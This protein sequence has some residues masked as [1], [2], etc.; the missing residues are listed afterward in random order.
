MDEKDIKLH[1][2]TGIYYFSRVSRNNVRRY[3]SSQ[4]LTVIVPGHLIILVPLLNTTFARATYVGPHVTLRA[5]S[6]SSSFRRLSF[7]TQENAFPKAFLS[8]SS[9]VEEGCARGRGAQQQ[10]DWYY[11]SCLRTDT[12]PPRPG[13]HRKEN[14]KSI[15]QQTR[16]H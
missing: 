3:L 13:G 2:V 4:L 10:Q 8:D 1:R 7:F 14:E 6:S 15:M 16:V 11:Q 12:D 5:Q 9:R